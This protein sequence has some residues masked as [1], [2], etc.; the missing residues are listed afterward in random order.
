VKVF[1]SEWY[2]TYGRYTRD[3]P[4]TG[5]RDSS[6]VEYEATDCLARG[7]HS[8]RNRPYFGHISILDFTDGLLVVV[9]EVWGFLWSRLELGLPNFTIATKLVCS[10]AG[11][12][13]QSVVSSLFLF[14]GLF[15]T[16]AK[17]S[18]LDLR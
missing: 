11:K 15:L 4:W 6:V 18:T 3:A 16:Q 7:A 17:S 9:R 2:L 1:A 14:P 13:L 5:S 12:T 10:P 8:T